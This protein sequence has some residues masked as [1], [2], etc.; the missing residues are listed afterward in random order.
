MEKKLEIT[1][2]H[3]QEVDMHSCEAKL[4]GESIYSTTLRENKEQAVEE[5]LGWVYR[6][7]IYLIIKSL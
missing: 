6:I 7:G 5:M 3:H 1:Y 2:T 4:N